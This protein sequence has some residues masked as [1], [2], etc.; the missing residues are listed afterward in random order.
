MDLKRYIRDVPNFP[1]EGIIFKDLTPLL[2]NNEALQY[3]IN[4]FADKYKNREIKYVAG[5][6]SRGFIFAAPLAYKLN[7]GFIPIRKPNKLPYK[8]IKI[9]YSLEYGKDALEIHQDA[10]SPNDK[11]LLIDD[12]LATGGTATAAVKLLK[13]V[14]SDVIGVSFVVELSF[15]NGRKNLEQEKVAVDSIVVY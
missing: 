14:G 2:K 4:Y 7:I 12:V 10:L 15:L 9:E 8:T 6:E 11:V 5:I 13:S 3:V 1:K